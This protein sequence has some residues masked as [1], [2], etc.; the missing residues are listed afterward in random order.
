[1]KLYFCFRFSYFCLSER[2][3]LK[4]F[5]SSVSIRLWTCVQLVWR[6]VVQWFK[7]NRLT[8]FFK[9][10]CNYTGRLGLGLGS[11]LRSATSWRFITVINSGNDNGKSWWTTHLHISPC[12]RYCRSVMAEQYFQEPVNSSHGQLVTPIFLWRV[13]RFFLRVVWR[14]DCRYSSHELA[15]LLTYEPKYHCWRSLSH[16][17]SIFM[18]FLLL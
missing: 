7:R 13:D 6:T 2:V 8:S 12:V 10:Q 11:G 4:F 15:C 14:V 3:I 16:L 17:Q 1:V 18:L 9:L 5:G